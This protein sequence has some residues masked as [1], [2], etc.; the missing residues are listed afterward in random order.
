MSLVTLS[1]TQAWAPAYYDL[2]R[3]GET[4][5]S[6]MGRVCSELAA[7][8]SAIA[9]FGALIAQDFIG[10][11]LDS[12]YEAAGRIVPWII[13]AYLAHSIFTMFSLAVVQAKETIWLMLVSF[14]ALAANTVLNFALIPHWGMYGAAYAT[15]AA[16][17]VEVI[18]MYLVAQRLYP[19]HYDL[20]RILSS[21]G[22]FSIALVATQVNWSDGHR[23]I[24][25][26]VA[27]A[28]CLS[29]LSAL[30]LK[31]AMSLL[32]RDSGRLTG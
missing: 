7:V 25:L 6:A 16:Y 18:V 24:A 32:R 15:I 13:G 9:C 2:A 17:V 23:L 4:G 27:S 19:L 28:L 31:H 10:H 8:L 3:K 5:R 21:V 12:R 30:G 26:A 11:F 1:L 22:V 14:V 29:L 20:R